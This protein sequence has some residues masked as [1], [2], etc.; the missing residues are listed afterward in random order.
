VASHTRQDNNSS[1]RIQVMADIKETKEAIAFAFSLAEA[2]K[3]SLADGKISYMDIGNFISPA[4][5]AGAAFEGINEVPAEM[6]DLD[7]AEAKELLDYVKAEFNLE[8]AD[9]EYKI[10]KALELATAAYQLAKSW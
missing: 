9:L 3:T 4:M 5:K 7:E 1:E 10:E 8:D 2:L 6:K